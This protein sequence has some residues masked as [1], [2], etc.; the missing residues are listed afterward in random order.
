MVDRPQTQPT[1]FS[2]IP[3]VT[4]ED[5]SNLQAFEDFKM[6]FFLKV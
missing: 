6:N 5:V 2:M 3:N 4:L 1:K